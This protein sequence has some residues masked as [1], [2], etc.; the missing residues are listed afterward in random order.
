MIRFCDK[1]VCCISENQLDKRQL[2]SYF[3]NGHRGESVCV[4]DEEGKFRGSITYLSIL[5]KELDEAVN[6]DCIIL[7]DNS[8]E[9]AKKCFE[10]FPQ[11]FGIQPALPVIDEDRNLICYAYQDEEADQE[12]RMLDE[13]AEHK[14]ALGFG[15]LYPQYDHV[16]VHGCNELSFQFVQYLKKQNISVS[17]SGEL[18]EKFNVLQDV[19]NKADHEVI[20]YRNLDIYGEGVIPKENRIELRQSVSPEFECIDKIY[21]TNIQHGIIHNADRSIEELLSYLKVKCIAILGV[22]ANALNLYDF[23]ITNDIDICCFISDQNEGKELFGKNVITRI[24]AV[25]TWPEIIFIQPDKKYSAWGFGETNLYHG[26]G[27]KRNKRFY[28]IR[29]YIEL[30]QNGLR[31][32]IL[33]RLEQIRGRLVLTGD[34][35]L[36]S[37][38]QQSL[39]KDA[40]IGNKNI[41]FFDV[42]KKYT[43]V[44]YCIPQIPVNEL[45][46]DDFCLILLPRYYAC[47]ADEKRKVVYRKEILKRYKEILHMCGITN[48]I[49]YPYE[50]VDWMRTNDL[51]NNSKPVFTP[52]RIILGSINSFSGNYL[53]GGIMDGHPDILKMRESVLCCNLYSFC[54]RLSMSPSYRMLEL[55][56]KLLE[57]DISRSDGYEF[58]DKDSFNSCM[59]ELLKVKDNFTSQELFVILHIAYARMLGVIVEDVSNMTIY[60]EPHVVPRDEVEHYAKW[61]NALNSDGYIVNIV[62]NSYMRAGSNFGCIEENRPIDRVVTAVYYPEEEKKEFEHWKRIVFKFEDLKL[63]PEQELRDFCKQTGLKWSE[64]LLN[65]KTSYKAVSG[66]DL[67]P[68]YRT[69]EDYFS[70]FDRFRI[71]LITEPWQRKYGYPYVSSLDFSRR[72][73][74]EMFL[75]KFRFEENWKFADDELENAFTK[76]RQ[77]MINERLWIVRRTDIIG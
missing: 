32:L 51:S 42:L 36:C 68:I 54:V 67:A 65:V 2:L 61:L 55:F 66:F 39:K 5:G 21:E 18:W 56:W 63:N 22:D 19:L 47:F 13:L 49:D 23:L 40:S 30:G 11:Q 41:V 8:W 20:D 16:T 28:L 58:P 24:N 45:K 44:E 7:R 38:M 73:L 35:W 46:P 74:Q 1:E 10:R 70:S 64:E 27:Y 50:D 37:A 59:E 72:Q 71:C 33:Y 53:F 12:L 4:L 52:Q 31:N 17:V 43:K 9:E 29:D 26:L 34:V 57:K 15:D 76:W 48:A 14:S 69:W 62:R 75:K 3:M 77:K 6:Q 25:E 60:W